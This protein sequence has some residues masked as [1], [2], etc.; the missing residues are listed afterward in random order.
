LLDKP[1][2]TYSNSAPI[3]RVYNFSAGPATLPESVLAE[4]QNELLNFQGQ[5][6]SIMEQSHRAK[7][8]VDV[9]TQ[10]E[11]DLRE[12]LNV[13]ED[14]S[15]L[16]LQGGATGQFSLIPQNLCQASDQADYI[17]TG[18]WSKKAV[19]HAK[20]FINVNVS[21]DASD[22][23]FT[24]ITPQ[25]DWQLTAE[26]E[27]I[28]YCD[29]ETVH[30]VEFAA[31]PETDK[32][33]VSDMSSNILSRHFD[34][35]KFGLIY[36]GAQKNIGPAGLTIVIVRNDWLER[37]GQ[38]VSPV[39]NYKIMAAAASMSNTPPTFAWYT[40]GKVF[41]WLKELGGVTEIEKRNAAKASLLYSAID[42][43]DFYANPVDVA[44]RSRMN[45]PFTLANPELDAL[46]LEKSSEQ[47]MINLK[48]HRSVGG[49]RA[50]LYNPM[51]IEGVQK[52]V[53]FMQ[54]FEKEHA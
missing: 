2:L 54:T 8:F 23:K 51:P 29:N 48:G 43:S 27:Y 34:V 16:F 45:I 20:D 10:A 9:A 53:D 26:A 35:S 17:I 7:M 18:Q 5:G 52:L 44:H 36:A 49:M 46:F 24:T 37:N 11:S 40:A 39:F 47:G 3:M 42:Q 31:T 1:S 50:S 15:I 14:Y 41:T 32:L 25:S 13:P 38:K 19:A 33:L 4:V 21:A 30:G 22:S 6:L 12:L 28:H